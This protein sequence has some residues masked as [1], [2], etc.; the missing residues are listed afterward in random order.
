MVRFL[1]YTNDWDTRGLIYQSSTWHSVGHKWA[2]TK[3]I[4]DQ[5]DCYEKDYPKLKVHDPAYPHPDSLRA[6]V[7][8]GEIHTV[9]WPNLKPLSST[10]GS[11]LIVTEL[12]K[13]DP[14]PLYVQCW[15]GSN[16]TA[17]AIY[18]LSRKGYS[19]QKLHAM[20]DKLVVFLLTTQEPDGADTKD[21]IGKNYPNVRM[22]FN[23]MSFTA[24][25]ATEEAHECWS[26]EWRDT[27]ICPENR[28]ALGN[29]IVEEICAVCKLHEADS[30]CFLYNINNGLR[31]MDD[32]RL[33]SW[34]GRFYY[35][36]RP[37]KGGDYRDSDDLWWEAVDRSGPQD[38]DGDKKLHLTRWYGHVAS[39]YA[40]RAEW[41][42]TSDFSRANHPP[43]VGDFGPPTRKVKPGSTVTLSC[44]GSSDPDGDKLS[45][46]WSQY[47]TWTHQA[48]W[49]GNDDPWSVKTWI[50]IDNPNSATGASFT[51]PNEPGKHINIILEVSDDGGPYKG[52]TRYAQIDFEISN[53][54][55]ATRLIPKVHTPA[56]GTGRTVIFGI[57]GRKLR[58]VADS[59]NAA[60]SLTPVIVRD[61][62]GR[63][64]CRV[65][66][67]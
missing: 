3:W 45:Y 44:T 51:V 32:P 13:D 42:R 31:G 35:F 58:S 6:V 59:P 62:H 20:L 7:R 39:D 56:K 36:D 60:R 18:D 57:N 27:Y 66:L 54:A 38:A 25:W 50:T 22:L 49:H 46:K 10:P 16:T 47:Y 61:A 9:G 8:V 33:G 28:G 43:V 21:W 63:T 64:K 29:Y 67:K 34:G 19:T 55:T 23:S 12:E 15:G 1:H 14:R 4:Q 5:I 30:P 41:T 40:A 11:D 53:D 26:R 24:Y 2:G 17:Q 65:L 52:L 37:S 48:W